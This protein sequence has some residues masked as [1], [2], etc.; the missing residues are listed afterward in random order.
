MQ[1]GIIDTFSK[2]GLVSLFMLLSFFPGSTSTADSLD[3]APPTFVHLFEWRWADIAAECETFLGPNGIGAVQI[4][5]PQ[6]HVVLPDWDYPWWQR[7]QPVSYQLESRSG[8]RTEL[9]DMV[10]RCNRAG[11]AIYADAVINHM[12]G[13]ESGTGS[14]G[15]EFTKYSYPGLYKPEDF[16]T[17]QQ[18]VVNYGDATNVTQCEL[19]GLADLDTS[20]ERVQATL[21]NYLSDLASLGVQGF[22]IDAAKHIQAEELGQILSQFRARHSE[23]L[24]IYQEVIDPGTEAV[25][26]QDYYN[27]GNVIDF[28]YG[29][30][31]S[32]A[33]LGVNGQ[34]LANLQT[35][36]ESWGLAPSEQ[37]VVFIDNHDKQRGHGGG[38]NYLTYK[39][40]DRYA[41]ANV[42][43]LAFP[44]GTAQVMS[45]YAFDDGDQGPPTYPDGTTRPIYQDGEPACFGEWVC[46]HRWTA[47]ANMVAFRNVTQPVFELT[48]WWSN[49][50]DQIAFG[51]GELGFVVINGEAETL[52]QTFQTQLPAGRYCN[53]IQG[54]PTA[55]GQACQGLG[56]P[57]TVNAQGQFTA[58]V[59][60]TSALA[61][62]AGAKLE[63]ESGF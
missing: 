11:V 26:K 49:G 16:N 13:M 7:Y 9:I 22:R 1:N 62:H 29:Q 34:T 23:A 28:K 39:D 6:E 27:N 2:R 52:T 25:R 12:A 18:P 4:S 5:P 17:C 10:Q 8:S 41:L 45:S 37:A 48:D 44:Y 63:E 61:L 51:R 40:G 50:T 15:T 53:V 24:Y 21:V 36:G 57:I 42:F 60:S 31:V 43:M 58:L 56:E 46:E 38:G 35:L 20:S 3:S 47:I 32:E 33:F 19:V 59:R 55:D 30:F 14:A 54:N